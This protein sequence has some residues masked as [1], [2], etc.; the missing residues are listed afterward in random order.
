MH[1]AGVEVALAFTVSADI[2]VVGSMSVGSK[3]EVAQD[4]G[5]S[6]VA[7]GEGVTSELGNGMVVVMVETIWVVW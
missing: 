7:F 1:A 5:S 3:E 2:I 4:V 6:T